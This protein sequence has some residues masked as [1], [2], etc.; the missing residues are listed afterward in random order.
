[1][2]EDHVNF[3]ASAVPGNESSIT[4]ESNGGRGGEQPSEEPHEPEFTHEAQHERRES[5][6]IAEN[7]NRWQRERATPEDDISGGD[8]NNEHTLD[9]ESI[10]L[11]DN[12]V[13]NF[14]SKEITK[15]K[16][17]CNIITIL[18]FDTCRSEKTKDAAVE[19]Y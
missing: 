19:Y 16:A 18:D 3:F 17:L 8:R 9:E 15:L 6:I 5:I 7:D 12:V 14:R 13:E 2:S 1:M 10:N 11:M 4:P